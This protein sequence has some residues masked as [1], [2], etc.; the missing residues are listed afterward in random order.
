MDT[1]ASG[2]F[3]SGPAGLL[4]QVVPLS[5]SSLVSVQVINEQGL[6]LVRYRKLIPVIHSNKSIIA[7]ATIFFATETVR[8][9]FIALLIL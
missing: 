1:G 2:D 7:A 5:S 6:L 9:I 8:R 3:S 4:L